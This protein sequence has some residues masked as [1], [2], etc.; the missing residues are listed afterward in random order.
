MDFGMTTRPCCKLQHIRTC[1]GVLPYFFVSPTIFGSLSLFAL[2][3]S[4][5]PQAEFYYSCKIVKDPLGIERM[6]FYL[7]DCRYNIRVL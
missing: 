4:Y 2:S 6:K 1:A 5:K 7:V 3:M